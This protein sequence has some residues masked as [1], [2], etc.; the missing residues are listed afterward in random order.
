MAASVPL[1]LF[2]EARLKYVAGQPRPRLFWN[3]S[4][5]TFPVRCFNALWDRANEA[6]ILSA[7]TED[8]VHVLLSDWEQRCLDNISKCNAYTGHCFPCATRLN[9][10]AE[11]VEHVMEA[12]PYS[13][14]AV[15]SAN[16][17]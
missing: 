7:T 6:A 10:S 5:Y 15:K 3:G 1:S 2:E 16:K 14:P 4:G 9:T 13:I 17:K 8:Q 11:L 12:H